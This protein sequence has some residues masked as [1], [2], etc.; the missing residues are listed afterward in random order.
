MGY[1]SEWDKF[2]PEGKEQSLCQ[3]R[4]DEG[5]VHFSLG[6]PDVHPQNAENGRSSE[7]GIR[8]ILLDGF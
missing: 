4:P 2:I 1:L 5:Q 6:Y 3:S 8:E 7:K